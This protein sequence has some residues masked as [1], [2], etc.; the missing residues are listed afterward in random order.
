MDISITKYY[1]FGL[2]LI[3]ILTSFFIDTHIPYFPIEISRTASG[4][5]AYYILS[6]GIPPLILTSYIDNNL[7]N[8][9]FMMIT[10]LFIIA[11]FDDKTHL[12]EHLIGVFLL[13]ITFLINAI[14]SDGKMVV[15]LTCF[16]LYILRIIIKTGFVLIFVFKKNTLN[17][18]GQMFNTIQDIMYN[19]E[20]AM[21]L[22]GNMN[23]DYII[24]AFRLCGMIQWMVFWFMSTTIK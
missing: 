11:C 13:M 8:G 6:I 3:T 21:L 17:D 4:G 22:K 2:L 9:R 20:N 7:T 10:S 5:L 1:V 14:Q 24:N 15:V 23:K 18:L 19:G 16:V 12:Y